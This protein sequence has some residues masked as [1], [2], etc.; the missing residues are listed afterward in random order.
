MAS[1]SAPTPLLEISGLKTYFGKANPIRAV[2]GVDLT[3]NDGETVCVVGE[4]GMWSV[5][6]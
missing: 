6:Q 2:D 3:I 4:S 1:N 5:V